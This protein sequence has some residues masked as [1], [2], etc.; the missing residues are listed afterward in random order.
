MIYQPIYVYSKIVFEFLLPNGVGS[1][2][3][4]SLMW[5]FSSIES[6]LILSWYASAE[7]HR[8]ARWAAT[9]A[10]GTLVSISPWHH[11]FSRLGFEVITCPLFLT[12][13]G[14]LLLH[15][16]GHIITCSGTLYA[17]QPASWRQLAMGCAITTM[18]VYAYHT[19]KL[20]APLLVMAF[21]IVCVASVKC[22]IV[23]KRMAVIFLA[24]TS[25][26]LMPLL[27]HELGKQR[28][29]WFQ[30]NFIFTSNFEYMKRTAP[31]LIRLSK[32]GQVEGL[33]LKVA[34]YV[35]RIYQK[36][37]LQ[38]G[39]PP[40]YSYSHIPIMFHVNR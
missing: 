7:L 29:E 28:S 6:S 25:L 5:G 38:G 9:V 20:F 12:V 37:A 30:R 35:C 16:A 21:C 22:K 36:K 23:R 1:V 13:G 2:R 32:V 40:N 17:V 4:P 19:A 26:V 39:I 24:T 33:E 31:G 34:V 3:L 27:V 14:A 10:T 18:S 15:S 11:H 8:Y